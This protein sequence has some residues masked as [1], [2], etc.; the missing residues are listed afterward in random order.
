MPSNVGSRN[1][2]LCIAAGAL[3]TITVSAFVVAAQQ[4]AATLRITSPTNGS[5]VNQGQTLIVEVSS[6]IG[7]TASKVLVIGEDPLDTVAINGSL[8]AALKIKIPANAPSGKRS[9]TAFAVTGS[10][11]KS[12]PITIDIEKPSPAISVT[13]L[14]QTLYLDPPPGI[15]PVAIFATFLDGSTI[16]VTRSTYVTYSS[17]NPASASINAEGIVTKLAPGRGTLRAIYKKFG[18]AVEVSIPFVVNRGE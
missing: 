14:D 9:L 5:V 13:A 12:D 3:L 18:R 8:P 4:H 15:T 10:G 7:E 2:K 17:D 16:N 11:A 6:A 1:C